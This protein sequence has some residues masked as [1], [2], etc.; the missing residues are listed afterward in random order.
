M[1]NDFSQFSFLK[2]D[3][4]NPVSKMVICMGLI[5]RKGTFPI[6]AEKVT[7]AHLKPFSVRAQ[8]MSVSPDLWGLAFHSA[9][10]VSHYTVTVT[11]PHGH[12][13]HTYT[14]LSSWP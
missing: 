9:R 4:L 14:C 5:I 7:Y 1:H 10:E 6:Y 13:Y 12:D 3:H 8:R 2:Y 11:F